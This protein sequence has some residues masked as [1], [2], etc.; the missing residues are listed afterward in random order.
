MKLPHRGSKED[1]ELR[2]KLSLDQGN[3]AGFVASWIGKLI[4]FSAAPSAT[5]SCP[6][7]T[8][9]ELEFF[10]MNGKQDVWNPAVSGGLNL[11]ETKVVAMKLLSSGAFNE[12]ERF[13][14]A[15]F[16]SVDPNSRLSDVA[17]DVLK[18]VLAN[19]SLENTSIVSNLLRVYLGTSGTDSEHRPPVSAPLKMKILTL[20]CKS[21]VAT[22]YG[23]EILHIV[24]E[25]LAVQTGASAPIT[26]GLQASKLRVRV[27]N[28]VNWV[29]RTAASS[30]ISDIAPKLVGDLRNYIEAQ[31]WPTCDEE[32]R[33]NPAELA[34]RA[35]GYESI[36]IL[37]KS[38]PSELLVD[39]D[40]DLLRWLF[41]SLGRDGSGGDIFLNIDQA[42]SS[43]LG[44]YAHIHE[45]G[46]Q[47]PLEQLLMHYAAI[48]PGSE[49]S[50]NTPMIRS[51]RYVAVRFANRCLPYSNVRARWIDLLAM[52][53]GPGERS[54]IIEEGRKGLDP[55][56]YRIL[57]PPDPGKS[58]D[59]TSTFPSSVEPRYIMPNFEEL[60]NFLFP[61]KDTALALG[62]GYVP[63]IDLCRT[64][65]FHEAIAQ[66][67]KAPIVDAD[68]DR[69]LDALIRNDE[70]IRTTII[71][72][73]SNLS[74]DKDRALDQL[75]DAAFT[76][77]VSSKL[78]N[79]SPA[80]RC[81][82]D[83][84][85]LGPHSASNFLTARIA[86]LRE[87]IYCNNHPS[88]L[89]AGHL[90]GLLSAHDGHNQS[91]VDGMLKEF[92]GKVKGW[93]SAVGSSVHH[94]HGSMLAL[95]Y[96]LSRTT[97]RNLSSGFKNIRERI[98]QISLDIVDNGRDKEI[99]EAA[100][101]TISQ[102]SLFGIIDSGV[103]K[104]S[105]NFKDLSTGL[106]A[107]AKKGDK[108]AVLALGYIAM[109]CN[110][111]EAGESLLAGV[112]DSLYGLH[113]TRQP[114]L[115]FAVGSALSCAAIGWES[116]SLIGLINVKST[117]PH[118]ACRKST[119]EEMIEKVL[120]SCEQTKPSLRQ[121]AVIWLL[122]LVQYCGHCDEIQSRLK[123][124]QTA[125][126]G[127]LADKESLNQE[128]ASRGLTL[129][130]EKGDSDVKDELVRDLVGSFTAAK[131]S[132]SGTVSEET[133]LFDSGAL[134]TGDG[135]SV[136]T[137]K[138]IINLAGEVG[139]PSLVYRFMS[140]AS[141]S[142]IWSSRAAFGRFGLSRILSDSSVDGY[143]SRNP[144]LYSALYRYR[145]DP[146][147]N[148]RAAMNDIWT[149][150]VKDPKAVVETHFGRILQ[151]LFKSILSK[152][153][154]TREASCAALADLIQGRPLKMYEQ[155]LTRIWE[156]TFKVCDD[157]K[158]TVRLAAMQLA[159]VLTGI[160][161][162]SLEAGEESAANAHAMLQ[163]VLP[164]LLS[165]SG[166]E[167]SAKDVQ[168]FSLITLMDIIEKASSKM[169]RPYLAD[170]VGHLLALLSAMEPEAVNYISLNVDKYGVTEQQLDDARLDSVKLSPMMEAIER[171]LDMIDETSMKA[172]NA[173]LS[174]AI[175]TVIGLPSKVGVSRVLVT[176]ATRHRF[177]FQPYA[178]GFLRL[179]R[180]QVV[181]RN[182]TIST[183]AAATCGYLSRIANQSEIL[184]LVGY[185]KTLYFES[186]DDRHR[187]VA[188]EI[189]LSIGKY[190]TD[191]FASLANICLPFAFFGS[192]D[193]HEPA[194][195]LFKSAWEDN[196]GGSRAVLLYL[197]EII[198]LSVRHLGSPRWSIKHTAALTIADTVKPAGSEIS[199]AHSEVMWP[200][201]EKAI[202]GKTWEGKERV[203][204]AFIIFAKASCLPEISTQVKDQ[205]HVSLL[206]LLIAQLFH[207]LTNDPSMQRIIVRESKRNNATYRIHAFSGLGQFAQNFKS[208]FSFETVSSIVRPVIE[209]EL[210][211]SSSM[212]ID[213]GRYAERSSQ[214]TWV[215]VQ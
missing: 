26:Q 75:V 97:D 156:L 170:L 195:E 100:V 200:A 15:L 130:Y 6:G 84:C 193:D 115:H 127:F 213:S 16:A 117:R 91:I 2:G 64:I 9:Q 62:R 12:G 112:I 92:T 132:L 71:N 53:G 8:T 48:E 118:T 173:S 63:A 179:I 22:T 196:V 14:P 74:T 125:F 96:W 52:S 58:I 187:T 209:E 147:T 164:F 114:E 107:M 30:A 87:S 134:P 215:V 38:S 171:C 37:A 189:L 61:K 137:Y 80:G 167:A 165:P 65:L 205:M 70:D 55:Y 69:N 85:Q 145:F 5:K 89:M 155:H 76:G 111:H 191:R 160:L 144:K 142:A 181:D 68:W 73:L 199:M 136:T 19:T 21:K 3:D 1:R 122:C 13:L 98:I 154:R 99:L 123:R 36:G 110:E 153:W 59:D 77:F 60:V 101:L 174:N 214:E 212:D 42:L 207:G 72:N 211:E 184:K 45:S 93:D 194:K 78:G 172:L 157:I 27:F 121:A 150:L 202:D 183:T 103:I 43:V 138:D 108:N 25:G 33:R 56:W 44:A 135:Q 81:L 141:N 203:L 119:L 166:L 86:E 185:S 57:N 104:A 32:L 180:K 50:S 29:A 201:I 139:D 176:L 159:R 105:S 20:L 126:K 88:R 151:D 143:L 133:Q 197:R 82:L 163:Q 208:A 177:L 124:C 67:S 158:A 206:F 47:Q 90:F 10:H 23:P 168:A 109:Q 40:L 198:D 131:S 4:L 79:T 169:M 161:V 129:V 178:D 204:D 116:K 210:E 28:F 106:E 17:D 46:L 192:H 41:N 94:V 188:G 120:E 128:A 186:E 66:S 35:Y 83:V 39:S 102:L 140:L 175:R 95:A 18:G 31:G 49:D 162:R 7:L 24:K 113:E 190:A 149:S 148:V 182:D 51:T 146:N 34:S 11:V 152:E 54:E